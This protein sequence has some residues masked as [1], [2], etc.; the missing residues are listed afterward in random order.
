MRIWYLLRS[1]LITAFLFCTF[2]I[3]ATAQ[4]RDTEDWLERCRRSDGGDRARERVC[5][6]REIR[7]PV[8][9]R[10][11]TIDG[12][13]NGGIAVEGWDR[14][15]ILVQARITANAATAEQARAMAQGIRIATERNEVRAEGPASERDGWWSVSYQV[16]VPR[17]MDL[18]LR[19]T[20]GGLRVENVSGR[21]EVET[22]N[23]GISLAGVSGDVRGRTSNGGLS[24]RLA[25][26]RWEGPGLD[27]RTTNGGVTL[28]VPEGYSAQLETGT[29]NGSFDTEIPLM[30]RFEGRVRSRE[31]S[32][33]L[34]QGGAPIRV[35]TTNGSVRI[36]RL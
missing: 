9:G 36:R 1:V 14:N 26:Q 16:F 28:Q 25:G 8:D 7:L 17:R 2:S 35:R 6:V 10:A 19:A 5:E 30:V 20:N 11:L 23:G 13:A 29:V 27:L 22:A 31:I 24:V 21:I 34:G 4:V 15:E 18:N 32:T 12:R 33:Q 3:G